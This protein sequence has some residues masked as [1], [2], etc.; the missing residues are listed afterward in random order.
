MAAA[1]LDPIACGIRRYISSVTNQQQVLREI[2]R[3]V[4]ARLE[5]GAHADVL[6][7]GCGYTVQVELPACARLV[8]LDISPEILDKHPGLH[9]RIV[10]DIETYPLPPERFDVVICWNVLEHLPRPRKAVANMA[11]TLKP[12]GLLVVG[13]PNIW[14]LKGLLTKLTPHRFHIWVYRRVL[15]FEQAGSPDFG[16]YR[17][18]LR[19][20]MS[21]RR[22]PE[23]A[24]AASLEGV[25]S[26]SYDV[27][28]GLPRGSDVV[29]SVATR[30][31]RVV[32]LGA[33]DAAASEHVAVF[34][35]REPTESRVGTRR[36]RPQ[37]RRR[38]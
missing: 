7:A 9:A 10:G 1:A 34:E 25:Y 30:V 37:Y 29:W 3:L 8:G 28:L 38:R 24:E 19:L 17:T 13:A 15:G 18:Y 32:T 20:S 12:G 26:S 22:L 5:R 31:A 36:V 35:K 33:W 11:R 4:D 23:I 14:S 6:D 27:P 2:Q 16:P 21:P